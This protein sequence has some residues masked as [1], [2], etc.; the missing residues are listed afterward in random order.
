[1]TKTKNHGD[2]YVAIPGPFLTKGFVVSGFKRLAIEKV[3][4][5]EIDGSIGCHGRFLLETFFFLWLSILKP[6]VEN[7]EENSC[8][9]LL[10]KNCTVHR[11]K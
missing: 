4:I 5:G 10:L 6:M 1:M 11:V 8:H 7:K 3:A 9:V 2:G